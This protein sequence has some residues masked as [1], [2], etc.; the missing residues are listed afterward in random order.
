MGSSP[1]EVP[2]G[3]QKSKKKILSALLCYCYGYYMAE[4]LVLGSSGEVVQ[5]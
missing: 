4:C 1:A 5:L 3:L 2:E